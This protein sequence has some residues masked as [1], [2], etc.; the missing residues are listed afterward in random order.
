MRIYLLKETK[1]KTFASKYKKWGQNKG[2]WIKEKI[3]NVLEGKR[4]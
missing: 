4:K 2:V 3:P 1:S